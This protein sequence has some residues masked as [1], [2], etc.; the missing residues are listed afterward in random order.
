[1]LVQWAE[2]TMR[3]PISQRVLPFPDL[4][5][6]WRF[7]RT[8]CGGRFALI[9]YCREVSISGG[10]DVNGSRKLTSCRQTKID[11]L[12]VHSVSVGSVGTRPRSR[13]RSR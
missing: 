9:E 5:H 1:M 13:F 12:G 4:A 2:W 6:W 11:Q 8:L 7:S 10:E 3:G